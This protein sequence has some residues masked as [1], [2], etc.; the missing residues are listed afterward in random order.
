MLGMADL[1]AQ[2]GKEVRLAVAS[3]IPPRYDFLHPEGEVKRFHAPGHDYADCDALIVLDTGTWGQLGELGEWIRSSP[4]EKVVIDHHLT[5]DLD[6]QATRLVDTSAEA[7]GRLVYE[8]SLALGTPLRAPAAH[9]VFVAL[10]MDT[11]WFRHRNTTAATYELAARLVERGAQPTLAYD[12]L[13]EQNS[14]GRIL[15]WARVLSRMEVTLGGQV[16]HVS[17]LAGDYAATGAT[18][19]DSED[20]VNYTRSVV[21]VEIGLFFAEQPAGGIKVSFR[22]RERVDVAKI[23]EQFGGGGHRLASGAIL[24]T[25]LDVA[26]SRVLAA[27][28][29]ALSCPAGE[30]QS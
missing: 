15:L 12:S 28:A 8:A 22:S 5:Q 3:V 4:A 7:T 16:C 18:P 24:P 9:A 1:L 26:R 2:R 19:Q 13:F 6:L 21:G 23:A 10:A 20:L 29:S 14:L 30:S 27:V 11:G 17:L 25:P